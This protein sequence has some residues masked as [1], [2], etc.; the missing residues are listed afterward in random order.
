MMGVVL[1][2]LFLNQEQGGVVLDI[3]LFFQLPCVEERRSEERV[4]WE[5]AREEERVRS[6]G[7]GIIQFKSLKL[8][9]K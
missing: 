2:Y 5:R 4:I 8:C 6:W 3:T 7:T 9:L 1:L